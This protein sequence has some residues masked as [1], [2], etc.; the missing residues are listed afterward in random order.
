MALILSNT[1]FEQETNLPSAKMSNA[2]FISSRFSGPN[3]DECINT[4]MYESS[5]SPTSARRAPSLQ[6]DSTSA[7]EAGDDL[8]EVYSPLLDSD[9]SDASDDETMSSPRAAELQSPSPS[10]ADDASNCVYSVMLLFQLRAAACARTRA[11]SP[12]NTLGYHTEPVPA[13]VCCPQRT[14]IATAAPKTSRKS[15]KAPKTKKSKQATAGRASF[16][17]T[18][19]SQPSLPTAATDSWNAKQ[20][21]RTLSDDEDARVIRSVRSILNKLTIEKFESLFCQLVVCGISTPEH[22]STLMREVFDKATLQHQFI[23]MY[24]ELCVRLE[25]DPHVAAVVEEAGDL[26]NFRRLLLNQC[27]NAFEQ[28]LEPCVAESS[29]DE[30][31]QMRRKQQALGNI[32]LIGELIVQGMVSTDL[33][34]ECC[35]VL[36]NSH[37][38][39]PEALES[40][41]ALVMVAGPKF[42]SKESQYHHKLEAVFTGMEKLTKDKTVPP[43]VRFL[44]RDVLDVREAGWCTSVNQAALKAAPMKLDEVREKAA[45]EE[46]GIMSPKRQSP[47]NKGLQRLTEICRR[48]ATATRQCEDKPATQTSGEAIASQRLAEICKSP[49]ANGERTPL[50]LK[51]RKQNCKQEVKVVQEARPVGLQCN[52]QDVVEEKA[53]PKKTDIVVQPICEL[54]VPVGGAEFD[55]VVFRRALAATLSRFSSEKNV[56][57]A[58]QY[59]RLQEVPLEFQADQFVD[60]LSRIVEERRGAV[61]RCEFAFAAG[62]MQGD[63]S[64]FDKTACFAGIAMFFR[65]VYDEMC[66]EVPRLPAIIRSEFVPAMFNI[67]RAEDLDAILP[68]DMRSC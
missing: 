5:K 34:M 59:I 45:S 6:E 65:D 64:P 21:A 56:A 8:S 15:T 19:G 28:L 54:P 60:I 55:L 22:I 68:E 61:R 62:L 13:D 11:T 35:N 50:E 49:V 17:D 32:K 10:P 57:A 67:F 16:A 3:V 14:I 24:A 12:R 9:A 41:A 20:R 39:C 58:V 2:S 25:S 29:V 18:M 51:P 43:R 36:L 48:P 42:D 27:Q 40:L 53:T 23:P 44:L 31:L 52:N 33:L 46:Q 4:S 47:A 26:H 30:E 63:G 38:S 66:A 7:S 37:S 1:K